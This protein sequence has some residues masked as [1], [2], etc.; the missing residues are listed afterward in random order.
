MLNETIFQAGSA[1]SGNG[2]RN[3]GKLN[4]DHSN[5]NLTPLKKLSP[6][7]TQEIVEKEIE[8]I[9]LIEKN[10][11]CTHVQAICYG[12]ARFLFICCESMEFH[13]LLHPS[14]DSCGEHLC[15]QRIIICLA[16]LKF[17]NK[18]MT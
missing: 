8:I 17:H 15:D 11:C 9:S 3:C 16:G 7:Q 4:G 5:A 12:I 14:P 6:N 13:L 10:T 2:S 1:R 18:H